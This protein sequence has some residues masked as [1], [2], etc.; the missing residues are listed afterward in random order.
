M[1]S[2][3]MANVS[4]MVFFFHCKR[5]LAELFVEWKPEVHVITGFL[6]NSDIW[7]F[8]YFMVLWLFS[9]MLCAVKVWFWSPRGEWCNCWRYII[10]SICYVLRVADRWP[11]VFFVEFCVLTVTWCFMY[12]LYGDIMAFS[13]PCCMIP[14]QWYDAGCS[15]TL[16]AWL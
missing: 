6:C 9:D 3:H 11:W 1:V 13:E 4:D 7:C 2:F 8:S 14:M 5:I 12:V 10:I 15:V 16:L